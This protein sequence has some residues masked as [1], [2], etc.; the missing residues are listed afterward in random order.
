MKLVGL[1]C[2]GYSSEFE[3]SLK[4]AQT[5]LDN[6]P[7]GYEVVPIHVT[8]A[9]WFVPEGSEKFPFS[10]ESMSYTLKGE[11]R[12]IDVGL[13]YIHGNPGENGKI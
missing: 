9:G 1:F 11:A 3:I 8:E 2:G 7:V 12:K 5:I 4:S 10:I 6:F 13:I